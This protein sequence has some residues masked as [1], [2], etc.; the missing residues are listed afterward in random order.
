MRKILVTLCF[1]ALFVFGSPKAMAQVAQDEGRINAKL[2]IRVSPDVLKKFGA[3]EIEKR[4]IM[5][6]QELVDD[7]YRRTKSER[8]HNHILIIPSVESITPLSSEE[9]KKVL[10]DP[11]LALVEFPKKPDSLLILIVGRE[12]YLDKKSAFAARKGDRILV[13]MPKHAQDFSL[14]NLVAKELGYRL[15]GKSSPDTI[16]AMCD[17]SRV[18]GCWPHATSFDERNLSLIAG[19]LDSF[20]DSIKL[21]GAAAEF[22]E[23]SSAMA[24]TNR[25]EK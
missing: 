8:Y 1:I 13:F 24:A 2:E 7:L 15:G 19:V 6:P 14:E 9:Y 11:K 22:P 5:A 17:S 21:A 25:Q 18:Y 12:F 16:S 4:V 23:K 10:K 20:L 3:D